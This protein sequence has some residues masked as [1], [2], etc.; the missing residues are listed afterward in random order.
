MRAIFW[1]GASFVTIGIL[2]AQPVPSCRGP[3]ELERDL[4]TKPST[5]AYN[6]KGAYF[7]N[8][9]QVSC[10]IAAFAAAIRLDPNSADSHFNLALAL[11]EKRDLKRATQEFRT[12]VRLNPDMVP[13]HNALGTALLE[14]EQSDAAEIEFQAALKLQPDSVYALDGLS[15]A[16][17]Q[18]KRYGAAIGYLRKAPPDPGLQIN[19]SVAL[20]KNGNTEEAI[21]ILQGLLKADPGLAEAHS[22]LAVIYALQNRF[23]EAA[24]EY[25][26]ALRYD[27]A[28]DT[29]RISLVRALVILGEFNDALPFIQDYLKRHASDGDGLTLRGTIYRGLGDYVR[30]EADLRRGVQAK[31]EDYDARYNLGFVL[32]KLARQQEALPHLEKA[33]QLRPDSTEARFQLAS[34]LKTLKQDDRA[35]IEFAA[36]GEQK[37]RSVQENVAGM[38]SNQANAFLQ[39]GETAKAIELYREVLRK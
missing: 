1:V 2:S 30:A 33:L 16:L 12:A 22:N 37:N 17:I 3:A 7:A 26:Q 27:T 36:V 29:S 20:S 23:R 28:N 11:R 38:K 39:A 5:D 21:A 8:K 6:A 10:A 9:H 14:T 34:V 35:R 19:L 15:K 32:A 24:D 18:Q 31:P 4:A 13:A 25:Y